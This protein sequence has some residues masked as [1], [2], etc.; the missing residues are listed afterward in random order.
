MK[1]AVRHEFGTP[2]VIRIEEHPTPTPTDDEI[3]LRVRATSLNLGD[4]ELLTGDPP[5]ITVLATMFAPKPRVVPPTPAGYR[6]IGRKRRG[7]LKTRFKILGADIAGQVEAVGR[8]VTRFQPGDEVFGDCGMSGFGGLAE[9]VCLGEKSVLARKPASLSFEQAAAIPQAAAI[10]LMGM[11]DLGQV[12]AGH[13]VLINGGG[14]GAGTFAIQLAKL[15]GAEVT[16]VDGP[17]KQEMMRR[18]GA[19]HVLDYTREDF[20]RNGERYDVLLDM[21]AHRTVFESRRSLTPDGIYLMAG[22]SGTAT[23]QS[24]ILGPL[25]SRFGNGR[26]KFLLADFRREDF[27]YM[28][29]LFEAGK[30]EPVIDRSYPLEQAADALQRIG[31]KLGLGKVI[32][33]C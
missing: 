7:L 33:T 23:W 32:V 24:A 12:R 31:D 25:L 13:K 6:F 9:Y 30:V 16:A 10:A 27:E 1:A 17:T 21:A 19:D 22:G 4:W 26:I 11:R 3:L 14:G 29:E 8:N 18:V 28:V 2:E 20:T 5:Y 15:Y